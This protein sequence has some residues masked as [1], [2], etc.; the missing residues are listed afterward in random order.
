MKPVNRNNPLQVPLDTY[1]QSDLSRQRAKLCAE[2][3]HVLM[4]I[5]TPQKT[6]ARHFPDRP[7]QELIR[8]LL[9]TLKLLA[10]H[11]QARA[12]SVCLQAW[13][14]WLGVPW[15]PGVFKTDIS[16]KG[17]AHSLLVSVSGQR[18]FTNRPKSDGQ[19]WL[20]D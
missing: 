14:L 1:A 4:R 13:L 12:Y 16:G 17:S 8:E 15:P 7:D 10:Q 3:L 18:S 20:V 2:A 6:I 11:R 9:D 19:R 5:G